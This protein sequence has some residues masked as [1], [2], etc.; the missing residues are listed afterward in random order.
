MAKTDLVTHFRYIAK[1]DGRAVSIVDLYVCE[2]RLYRS[3]LFKF[4]MN[5]K[6]LSSF[7]LSTLQFPFVNNVNMVTVRTS[8]T[9][10]QPQLLTCRIFFH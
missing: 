9:Q 2:V 8:D 6:P 7:S 10:R 1:K 5:I 3:V 4:T